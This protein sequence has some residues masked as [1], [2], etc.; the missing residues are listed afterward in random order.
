MSSPASAEVLRITRTYPA[1]R[2]RVFAA[3]TEPDLL[4][5]WWGPNGFSLPRAE[6]DLR[7]GG[8]YRFAMQPP[9]GDTA[10]LTG[11]FKEVNPPR[12]LVYT[13]AWESMPEFE[14]LVTIEFREAEGD[15]E[16]VITQERFSNDEVRQQHAVGWIGGLDRLSEIFRREKHGKA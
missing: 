13:W 16:V 4:K 8:R 3:F 12:R 6:V 2:Q 14:T 11:S 1:S 10:Y 9:Q 15:T 5:Q 7:V